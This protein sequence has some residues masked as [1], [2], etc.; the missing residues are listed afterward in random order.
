MI[1]TVVS[2]SEVWDI[3][4]RKEKAHSTVSLVYDCKN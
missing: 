3:H 1:L 4:K 2:T